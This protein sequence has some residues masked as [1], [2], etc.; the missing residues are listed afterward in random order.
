MILPIF[1]SVRAIY[2][3]IMSPNPDFAKRIGAFLM[4]SISA[5]TIL[6]ATAVNVFLQPFHVI[7][8]TD[9]QNP[10]TLAAVGQETNG[11]PLL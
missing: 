2:F 11:I 9:E 4:M 1:Q 5:T 8:A 7:A 3:P 10:S 6:G